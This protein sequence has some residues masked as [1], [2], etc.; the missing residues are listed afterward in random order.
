MDELARVVVRR[1]R[2]ACV[3]TITGEIDVSNADEIRLLLEDRLVEDAQHDTF[4]K[5]GGQRG[6][7]QIHRASRQG[8]TDAPV[9]R[10]PAFGDVKIGQHFQAGG[11]RQGERR[12]RRR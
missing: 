12:W 3:A 4:A 2:E 10:Q 9:L 11:D 1:R 8:E 5:L 6:H 7:T